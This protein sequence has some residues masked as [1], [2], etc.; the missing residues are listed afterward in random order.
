MRYL[1]YA[2]IAVFAA[3]LWLNTSHHGMRIERQMSE[4]PVQQ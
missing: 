4:H 3:S 1:L 2:A